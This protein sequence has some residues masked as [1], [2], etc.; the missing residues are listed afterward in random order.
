M[1][2]GTG[3]WDFHFLNEVLVNRSHEIG[4]ILLLVVSQRF[5]SVSEI[6]QSLASSSSSHS[7]LLG[8]SP[9][10]SL[11][12]RLHVNASSGDMVFLHEFALHTSRGCRVSHYRSLPVVV[13]GEVSEDIRG[14]SSSTLISPMTV[15]ELLIAVVRC[16]VSANRSLRRSMVST[17]KGW[18]TRLLLAPLFR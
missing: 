16:L 5:N 1:S 4:C 6:Q 10:K 8:D 2:L 13:S 18:V 9:C 14:T 12:G 11:R 15:E 3:A 17:T 7:S